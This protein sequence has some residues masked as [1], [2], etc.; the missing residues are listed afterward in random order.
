MKLLSYSIKHFIQPFNNRLALSIVLCFI[1]GISAEAQTKMF[2]SAFNRQMLDTV[3]V[4]PGKYMPLP[5]AGS[6]FWTDSLPQSV[7][8]SYIEYGEQFLGKQW[9]SLPATVFAEF[10]TNGNRVNFEALTF[11]KRKQLAAL[12][13]AEVAEGKGRFVPDIINGL[14]ST[15]EESWW[16]I[17]AHYGKKVP[18]MEDQNVDLF[19]AESAGLI[20]W[21]A[22]IL[23]PELDK[24][25][26]LIVSRINKEIKQ[27]ML[28]PAMKGRY[29]WKTAG[30]NWN[31]WICSNWLACVLI[32][33]S[34]RKAQLDAVEQIL[35]AMDHFV[36]AYPAD[37][38]CDEGPGYWD[39][40]AA[41][42]YECMNLLRT[43]TGGKIDMST[44]EKIRAMAS[45]AYKTYIENDYCITFADTHDNKMLQQLNIVYPFGLYL[46]DPVMREFAAYMAKQK[47]LLGN[48]AALYD[49]SGNYPTLARELFFMRNINSLLAEKPNEPLL[50]DVWLPNLQIMAARRDNMFVAMKGGHN[51]ESHNHN[52][53]GSFVVYADGE[54]LIIDPAVGE[55][56][57][58]TFSNRR[59]EIWT[60]QSQYHNLPQINGTDQRDGKQ[61]AATN[62]KYKKGSLTLNIEGAYPKEAGVKQWMRTVS[63]SKKGM[64]TVSE[65]Y[66]LSET[67]Q[68]TRLMLMTIAK[69]E[70]MGNGII[71]IGNRSIVYNDSQLDIAI[72]SVSD[73]LDPLLRRIWGND[74]YRIVMTVKGNKLR[75]K[76][77][78]RVR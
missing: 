71:S 77:E 3:L 44:N 24:F 10:K 18:V 17:P 9:H 15:L 7:R 22:Y 75:D 63:I 74:M 19:Q 34:D 69:P 13:M 73:K 26:P 21:T 47:N 48:A 16:G 46:N 62:A 41:S 61:F 12:V 38:G 20:A 45:Y 27:R 67:S 58:K 59:Y 2:A 68:P 5:Q 31:P 51:D 1:A 11:Q 33:E 64:V 8:Q 29:W 32:C 30:M 40:A 56:T 65:N 36:D 4:Q 37:G 70:L 49:K 55:Y 6:K 23:K 66:Q 28:Q 39:R 35:K 52:D 42:L 53:V 76:I 54:P 57:S 60:M 43:A 72:E 50:D 25:S 78:Y 14:W